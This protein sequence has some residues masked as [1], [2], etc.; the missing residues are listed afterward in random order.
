MIDLFYNEFNASNID[1]YMCAIRFPTPALLNQTLTDWKITNYLTK[2]GI[3]LKYNGWQSM[4]SE[5]GGDSSVIFNQIN[6]YKHSN[7]DVIFE[8]GAHINSAF[9][10]VA[11]D[12]F[13]FYNRQ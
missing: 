4:A 3:G 8:Q 6:R 12:P 2:K 13:S 9:A 11:G 1:L 10:E 5:W 7:I